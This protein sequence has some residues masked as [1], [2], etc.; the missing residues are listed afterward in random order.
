VTPL[1]VVK[2]ECANCAMSGEEYLARKYCEP[3]AYWHCL[4]ELEPSGAGRYYTFDELN[5]PQYWLKAVAKYTQ[6]EPSA[7]A[8]QL[9]RRVEAARAE[10]SA[11]QEKIYGERTLYAISRSRKA[12][13]AKEDAA[14]NTFNAQKQAY[15]RDYLKAIATGV[16]RRRRTGRKCAQCKAV[17][18]LG[19]AK[20]CDSC[21]K[22]RQRDS[23]RAS[24]DRKRQNPLLG[25]I[26]LLSGA[27]QLQTF[28]NGQNA[29]NG[30]SA[31]TIA[32]GASVDKL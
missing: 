14:W 31:T 19:R 10:F 2:Q 8:R 26:S 7:A 5:Y 28:T 6:Q 29:K 11:K 12:I 15:L 13:Y 25:D 17:K 4:H 20:Y 21:A 22:Q 30:L 3:K 18:V 23:L 9:H 1:Q 16:V 32:G 24:R 27:A